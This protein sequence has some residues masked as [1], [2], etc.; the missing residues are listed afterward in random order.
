M[1]SDDLAKQLHDKATRGK[2]ISVEEHSL[3]ENW[4][5]LQDSSESDVLKLADDEKTLP[6]IQVQVETALT[7]LMSVTKRIREIASENEALRQEIAILRRQL[8]HSSL[9]QPTA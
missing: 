9:A 7:Q 5:A 2:L 1:I 3:L 6:T 8:A 4:Y